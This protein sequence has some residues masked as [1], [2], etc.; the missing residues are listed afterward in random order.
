VTSQQFCEVDGNR[1]ADLEGNVLART[2]EDVVVSK[3]LKASR[4]SQRDS[5]FLAWMTVS[6]VGDA[7]APSSESGGR[8]VPRHAPVYVSMPTVVVP[9]T[10]Q[11]QLFGPTASVATIM[12]GVAK[13]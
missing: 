10:V 8:G 6:T 1:I 5:T 7:V 4:F 3:R 12:R 13:A 2:V 9:M 11:G